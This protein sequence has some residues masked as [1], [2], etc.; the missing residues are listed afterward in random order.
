MRNGNPWN[1]EQRHLD[2][3]GVEIVLRERESKSEITYDEW[4]DFPA[5]FDQKGLPETMSEL[6]P[7]LLV[8]VCKFIISPLYSMD[9]TVRML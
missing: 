4:L 7:R 2:Y 6:G 5:S 3:K 1:A 9:P 8:L